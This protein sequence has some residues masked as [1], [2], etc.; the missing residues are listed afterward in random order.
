MKSRHPVLLVEDD[1]TLREALAETLRLAGYGVVT[2]A[3]GTEALDLLDDAAFSA[4]V[5][6]YQMRPMD[7][8]TLLTRI[9]ELRP[10]L[11]VLLITAHGTIEHAVRCMLEGASDYLVKPFAAPVLVERLQKLIPAP[12][13]SLH[14]VV[15][16]DPS[17]VEL[18]TLAGR[19][20]ASDAT[21]LISGESGTGKEVL[22]R[23]VHAQS[24]R[25]NEAFVAVNCGAIPEA[26]LES[27]LFGHS[28]GAF[29]GA[30]RT[31][32]GLFAEADGGTIFLDEIGELPLSLQV[33]L[34]RVLQ[35]EEIR[36]LGE[37]KSRRV[38]VR[39]I[40]A[41]A[42]HLEDEIEAGR[43]REDLFYRLNVLRIH[44]PP[45]RERRQDVPLLVDHFLAHFRDTLGRPVRAI[46]DNAL[47]RLVGYA[48]PGNVR[49]LENVMER[50]VILARGDHLTLA[51]LP[52]NVS[53]PDPAGS[54]D[55]GTDL[56]LRRARRSAEIQAI[57]TALRHTGGNRTHAA[58]V[59]G[60][61]HRAL[62]Y[63]LKE[64]AIRD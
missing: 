64:Y 44:V 18:V 16:A 5:T 53:H 14:D 2:A 34:L 24:L 38:D 43:F 37:S 56:S 6:D 19:V 26:L 45:L 22:A 31:R 11:P 46:A 40:A 60:V 50:A 9:R 7:G 8:F 36:P 13:Q 54:A 35:E 59:L 62:L 27:E 33:K 57:R 23:A 47:D 12:S 61:S 3:D 51:E 41:T 10:H 63:K 17:T 48:W 58:R 21:V 55:A 4:V 49:E 28:K 30:D 52:T 32:R 39:V 20:A 1:A 42:R 15:I 25:R 29:T